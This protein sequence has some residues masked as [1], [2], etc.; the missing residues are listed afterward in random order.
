MSAYPSAAQTDQGSFRIVPDIS[1]KKEPTMNRDYI[2]IRLT[3]LVLFTLAIERVIT[4]T[5]TQCFLPGLNQR[6][7]IFAINILINVLNSVCKCTRE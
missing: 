2:I 7:I 6:M 3:H 4:P 1:V 5:Q